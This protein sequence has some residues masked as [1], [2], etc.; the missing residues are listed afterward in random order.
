[1]PEPESLVTKRSVRIA[2]PAAVAFDL[3]RDVDRWT[4]LFT[5]VA[6][7]KRSVTGADT[8]EITVWLLREDERV[9]AVT[10]Q[11]TVDAHAGRI[12]VIDDPSPA[13]F[14]SSRSEWQVTEDGENSCTISYTAEQSVDGPADVH[15]A[16]LDAWAGAF[17]AELQAAAEQYTELDDL[18]I[19]FEDELFI[20]GDLSDVYGLLYR[21]AEWPE[22]FPHVKRIVLSEEVPN[23]QF[24]D[25]DTVT[26]EG[27]SHTT[28]SV[29]VC[30]P[31][32]LIVYK[33]IVLPPLLNAH[34][35][36][37][38]FTATREGMIAA[39]KHTATIKR[40][41]LHL[42][43]DGTTVLDARKYLRRVLSANSM[44]NLRYAKE[45]AEQRAGH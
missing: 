26:P 32:S 36:H 19:S 45:Y 12:T 18:I 5:G 37:W 4:Q 44:A 42:L 2:A 41:G 15:A 8:D 33:Q 20:A 35:G 29:R 24:F 39:A 34:T 38:K 21:A 30:F 3:V 13:P 11:R 43:G 25:M 27:R 7:A 14:R 31:E 6:Y 28:R 9:E 10:S 17:L 16:R 23:V 1:M 40:S 22:R